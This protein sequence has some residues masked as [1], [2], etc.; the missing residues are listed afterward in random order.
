MFKIGSQSAKGSIVNIG[1]DIEIE[2]QIKYGR[3]QPEEIII[4]QKDFEILKD[5]NVI[6]IDGIQISVNIK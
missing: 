5:G 1:S 3:G 2:S 4:S 6:N